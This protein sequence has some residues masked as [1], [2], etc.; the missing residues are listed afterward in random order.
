MPANQ[1]TLNDLRYVRQALDRDRSSPFPP[2]I[3]VLWAGICGVGFVLN[4]VAP[5]STGLYWA[6][7]SPA[8]F[9]LSCWLGYRTSRA[10][11]ELDRREGMRWALHFGTLLLAVFIAAVA[12]ALGGFTGSQMGA[13]ALLL[14]GVVFLLA[15]VHLARPLAWVGLLNLAGVPAVLLVERWR[16][17]LVGAFLAA[18]FLA[19]AFTGRRRA[20]DGAA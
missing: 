16:W 11:G 13:V 4:D 6:I 5:T 15:G 14:C 9:L 20:R 3:A 10:G 19:V 17:T 1:P 18:A 2:S 12:V 8:G 7:A